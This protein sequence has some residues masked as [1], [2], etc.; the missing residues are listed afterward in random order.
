MSLA[1]F[2][3]FTYVLI[4][5]FAWSACSLRGGGVAS[6]RAAASTNAASVATAQVAIA[7]ATA[8]S[9]SGVVATRDRSRAAMDP[10][11]APG[12]APD[13]NHDLKTVE[14]DLDGD[15]DDDVSF[16][17]GNLAVPAWRATSPPARTR[18]SQRGE[19]QVDTSRFAAGTGLPRGPPAAARA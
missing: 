8:L 12:G 16:H 9:T 3:R 17:H 11:L 4:A 14:T 15:D 19:I 5:L 10:D 18:A 6:S 2:A 13:S 1:R 7:T